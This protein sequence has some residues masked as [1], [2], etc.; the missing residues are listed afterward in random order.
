[1]VA[2]KTSEKDELKEVDDLGGLLA[3]KLR[4]SATSSRSRPCRRAGIVPFAY[5]LAV[6]TNPT[7]KTALTQLVGRILRQP[8]GR[9]TGNR[10][11]DE[12]YVF[13][14]QRRGGELMKEIR[15][16]FGAE[17]LGDLKGR[18][19]E[20]SGRPERG[21][22][23][24][25]FPATGISDPSGASRAARIRHQ[26]WPGVAA[27]ALRTGCLARVPWGDVKIDRLL[28]LVLPDEDTTGRHTRH[29]LGRERILQEE[30][31]ATE[32]T[33]RAGRRRAGLRLRRE[34]SA[35]RDA[36]SVAWK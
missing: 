10:W 35:G 19:V 20:E 3:Q 27:R 7:S 24:G 8:D 16:G 1:M 4:R 9:K 12:S 22:R 33:H 26:R 14:F 32:R 29:G 5:V 17:G 34:P 28:K 6:L 11:L 15:E 31:A 18:I 21:A 25:D 23:D 36:E 2:V 13:C 30:E